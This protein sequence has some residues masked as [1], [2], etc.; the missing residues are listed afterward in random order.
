MAAQNYQVNFTDTGDSGNGP[1]TAVL[2][3]NGTPASGGTTK[4]TVTANTALGLGDV[5]NR[6]MERMRNLNAAFYD[7]DSE[8]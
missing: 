5:S 6:I 4:L 8:N 7:Q 3:L 1:Y 2:I